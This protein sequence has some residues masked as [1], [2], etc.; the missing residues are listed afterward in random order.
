M[1]ILLIAIISL[2][3]Q[4][5]LPWWIVAPVAFGLAY[6]SARSGRHAFR[7][8]FVAI[9]ILWICMALVYSL[10]NQNLLANRVAQ[11]FMLPESS[12]SWIIMLLI[13]GLIGGITAGVSALAGFYCRQAFTKRSAVKPVIVS[14]PG[15]SI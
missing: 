9:L 5:F 14:L 7:S 10:P 6:L 3:L 8:G 4:L 11:M 12:F 1:L 15:E 2:I 13:S